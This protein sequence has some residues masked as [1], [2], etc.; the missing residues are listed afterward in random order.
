MSLKMTDLAQLELG[1]F[2]DLPSVASKRLDQPHKKASV[3]E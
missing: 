3:H 2:L 1:F